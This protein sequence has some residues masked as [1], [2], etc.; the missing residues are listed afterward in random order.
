M[1]RYPID[2][3]T[4]VGR[5]LLDQVAP[6]PTEAADPS[7]EWVAEAWSFRDDVG[8]KIAIAETDA[9]TQFLASEKF[10][11]RLADLMH[12]KY[13]KNATLYDF[14]DDARHI[15]RALTDTVTDTESETESPGVG[16]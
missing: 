12:Y 13:G 15:V 8:R 10:T 2:P 14:Q 7:E 16:Q 9:I 11:H 3:T 5:V 4:D 1:S 6:A